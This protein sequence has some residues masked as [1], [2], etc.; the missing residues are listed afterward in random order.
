MH[1]KGITKKLDHPHEPGE[2]VIIRK[3]SSGYIKLAEEAFARRTSRSIKDMGGFGN[4]PN[5]KRC[6]KCGA[7]QEN[8]HECSP[9]DVFAKE[10]RERNPSAV[11]AA[12]LDRKVMLNAGIASWSSDQK[13][14]EESVADLNEFT[15]EWLFREIV[16]FVNEDMTAEAKKEET[17]LS[18]SS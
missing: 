12:T 3:V 10:E 8:D 11:D 18:S 16:S 5:F 9:L 4:V 13:V 1:T 2:W 7:Q 14:D 17:K 15:A 6:P